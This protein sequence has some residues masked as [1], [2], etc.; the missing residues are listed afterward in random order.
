MASVLEK[1]IRDVDLALLFLG[2][3][4]EKC[5]AHRIGFLKLLGELLA[6]AWYDDLVITN[7]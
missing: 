3:A 4:C 5:S 2:D 1:A 7:P 6:G